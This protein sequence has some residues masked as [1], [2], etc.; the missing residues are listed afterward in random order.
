MQAKVSLAVL[1]TAAGREGRSLSG[2]RSS[3]LAG[4]RAALQL[5][6]SL[7]PSLDQRQQLHTRPQSIAGEWG[8]TW[9]AAGSAGLEGPLPLLPPHAAHDGRDSRKRLLA[10]LHMLLQAE[11][12]T[13]A[14]VRCG[15]GLARTFASYHGRYQCVEGRVGGWMLVLCRRCD[16]MLPMPVSRKER[17]PIGPLPSMCQ[18]PPGR[19][20]RD[21]RDE[22][23]GCGRDEDEKKNSTAS[24]RS[25]PGRGGCRR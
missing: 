3:R 1:G 4:R 25:R 22:T 24:A 13:C 17:T 16:E 5:C 10:A 8:G 19:D 14:V 6:S 20:E 9:D 12:R 15:C 23:C 7:V 18:S 21:E 2:R 11:K